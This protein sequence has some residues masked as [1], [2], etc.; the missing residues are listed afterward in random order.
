VVNPDCQ[1][2]EGYE[3]LVVTLT[4]GQVKSGILKSEDAKH[5]RLMTC[6][7]TLLVVPKA[8]IEERARGPSAMPAD[9]TR[10][11]GRSEL[12]DLVEFLST[13]Q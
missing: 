4:N 2:A 3:T 11:L 9:L 12:R 7:A 13:L 10:H 6:E 1:I 8:D 5:V